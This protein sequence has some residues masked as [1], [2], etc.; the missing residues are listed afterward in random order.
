MLTRIIIKSLKVRHNRLAVAVLAVL[1]ASTLV[2]ALVNLSL[3]IGVRAGRELEAYGPNTLLVPRTAS[4]PAG[5]GRLAFGEVTG[6]GYL[7]EAVLSLLDSGQTV[8]VKAY[9]PF[10]YSIVEGKGQKIVA[11]GVWFDKLAG[12]APYWQLTGRW[13]DGAVADRAVIGANAARRLALNVGDELTLSSGG[14]PSAGTPGAQRTF[15]VAAVARVGGSED[16]QA[17]IPLA[18]AQE[19]AGRPGQLD[20][21]M[22]RL[23]ASG[24]ELG[25][26]TAE[27]ERNIPAARVRVVGQI[28]AAEASALFKVQLLIGLIT[29]L[30]LV[31]SALAVFST[32]SA[33]VLER[34][35]EVGLMKAL[36]ARGRGIALCFMAE[37]WIIGLGGGA[38][39]VVVGLGL[40]QLI[41]HNVFNTYLSFYPVVIPVTFLTA[42]LTTTLASLW[43]VSRALAVEPVIALRGE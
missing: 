24:P 28:A 40:G 4:L 36:G 26:I 20:M 21:V 37:A 34:A 7:D 11:T 32:L 10:L 14:N 12:L 38:A 15:L 6:E 41:A 25:R 22:I 13:P 8:P 30:V 19:L 16:N 3:D 18:A 1:L 35:K 17:F 31:V 29:A 33:S 27:M 43:P 42:V 39:G 2:T 9:A 23:A 5:A